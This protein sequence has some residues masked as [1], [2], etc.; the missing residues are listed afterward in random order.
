MAKLTQ[1]QKH[2][3]G[4]AGEFLVAGELLRR[5]IQAAVTYGNAKRSDVLACH[6]GR[7]LS[8]EV[9]STSGS[10]WVLGGVVPAESD[11]LWVLVHLPSDATQPPSY[12]VLASAELRK[13]V[14]PR[15]DAYM[16]RY[17]SKHGKAYSST[18]VVSVFRHEVQEC[19]L[20]AWHKVLKAL[21]VP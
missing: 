19:H 16:N 4:M 8:L 14:L 2:T 17:L 5:G 15:H 18:G 20:G 6:E 3:T 13:A 12:F 10:K 21:G 7:S 1:A 9:K 11:K